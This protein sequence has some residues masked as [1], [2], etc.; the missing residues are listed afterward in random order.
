VA[1]SP[2]KDS[3]LGVL[4]FTRLIKETLAESFPRCGARRDLGAQAG[5]SGHL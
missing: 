5:R 1:I 2:E 3:I 4:A